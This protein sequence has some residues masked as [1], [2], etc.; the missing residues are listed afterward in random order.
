MSTTIAIIGAGMAGLS[1]ATELKARGLNPVLFDKGR[2]PGGRM[3]TRRAQVGDDEV[4]FDHG[5]QYFTA[6]DPRFV[7]AVERWRA[8]SVAAPWPTA[9]ADAFV[10][11]PGMNGPVKHMAAALDV[12]WG[13][14][15]ERIAR[16]GTRWLLHGEGKSFAAEMLVCA[17]PA[18]QAA[19]LLDK[20]APEFAARAAAVRSRPCWALMARFDARL[21]LDDT[22]RGET[23]AWAA[24]N[25]AKPGRAEGEDWV[26][27]ASPEWS[28]ENLELDKGEVVP[29]LLDA[30]FLET[31]TKPQEPLH[32]DAHRWRYAMVGKAD[33]APALWDA[34]LELGVCGDWLAGPR[35]ENAFLSGL[36]LARLMAE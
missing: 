20:E 13:S 29:K 34:T 10:G 27:H 5:A 19:E 26:I 18:E 30:F 11:T 14:R 22:Y 9:G 7:K 8:A 28:A 33:G 32:A 35:V 4:R 3:A 36:E 2:G 12:S 1:C 31:G 23:I 16:D 6:R 17:I 24:R 15:I 21:D 25:S